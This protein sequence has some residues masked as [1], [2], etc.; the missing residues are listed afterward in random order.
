MILGF[1]TA[2][3]IVLSEQKFMGRNTEER[4]SRVSEVKSS[5]QDPKYRGT[6]G[7]PWEDGGT[8]LQA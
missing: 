6:R 3:R 7:I 8:T 1:R 2:E 4:E 5:V